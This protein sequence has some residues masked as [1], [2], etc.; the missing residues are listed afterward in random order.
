[1][2]KLPSAMYKTQLEIYLH[3]TNY[4]R[5]ECLHCHRVI[6]AG[7]F[8]LLDPA[9]TASE[10]LARILVADETTLHQTGCTY[11]GR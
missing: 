11:Q 7:D 6:F 10:F 3:P 9:L 8:S 4:L 1:M 5:I 2:I